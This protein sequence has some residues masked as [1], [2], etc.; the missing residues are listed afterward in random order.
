MDKPRLVVVDDELDI[1][2]LVQGRAGLLGFDARIVA[3]GR[4]LMKTLDGEPDVI[5]LDLV[6][7]DM[8]GIEVLQELAARNSRACIILISGYGKQYLEIADK[9]GSAHGLNILKTLTK[10]FR[11]EELDA[12]LRKALPGACRV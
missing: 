4:E 12:L 2:N 1:A 8:D 5:V 9:L 10:P 3:N 6:M 11:I 7:P